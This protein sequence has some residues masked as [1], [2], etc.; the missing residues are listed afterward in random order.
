M[1]TLTKIFA[2]ATF[3]ASVVSCSSCGTN[4]NVKKAIPTVKSEAELQQEALIKIHLDSLTND[5]IKLQPVGI[6]NSVKDGKV[7]LSEKELQLKP[8]YLVDPSYANNLQTLAQKYR[9]IAILAT[10]K[11]IANFYEMST[12]DY[13]K[14]LAKL[15]ADVNDSALKDVINAT[16][17][18]ASIKAF[19]NSA[20]ENGRTNLFWDAAGAGIIE[21]LYIASQ[22]IDKFLGAFDDESA[23]NT[24]YHITLLSI[25]IEDLANIN[26]EY[27]ELNESLKP[28]QVINAINLEQFKEQLAEAKGMIAV[29]REALLK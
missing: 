12:A 3:C 4:K 7:E 25:A 20:E 2:I 8:D 14:A 13:D 11:E 27:T 29:S 22:N 26:P 21:E 18:T 6:V 5:F 1:R 24:S 15:Y 9:A 23:S 28:L 17:Y 19:Y 10:D 16:D